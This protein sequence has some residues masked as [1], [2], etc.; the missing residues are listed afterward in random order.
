MEPQTHYIERRGKSFGYQSV[1]SG[2]RTV[3]MYSEING[4]PDLLWTDP[5]WA[6]ACARLAGSAK[7]LIFQLMGLGLSDAIDRVPTLEEQ[8]SDL[9]A[10]LD[11]EGVESATIL[12]VTSTSMPVLLFAAR[13]PERVDGLMLLTPFARGPLAPGYDDG[14]DLTAA[15]AAAL[16]SEYLEIFARWGEGRLLEVWDP[17]IAARNRRIEGILERAAATPAVAKA[18]LGAAMLGDVRELLPLI[19]AP[20]RVLR[21]KTHFIPE[22]VA[23]VVADGIPGATFHELP[24]NLPHMTLGEVFLPAFE[25]IQAVVEDRQPRVG[26]ERQLASILF[27]DIVGSTGL[28]EQLGDAKWNELLARH[29]VQ[30]AEHVEAAGGRLLKLIGDGSVSVFPGPAAAIRAGRAIAAAAPELD[31]RVRSGVHTGECQRRPGG[32]ISGLAVHIAARVGA[33]AAPG[34]VWV[35]RTVRDLV[36]GSGLELAPRGSHELKGL[37]ERWELFSLSGEDR[38]GATVEAQPS[39]M[40]PGDRL[41]VAA[42]RRA[43][44][45]MRGLARLEY[46]RRRFGRQ[47]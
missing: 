40:R 36:G 26:E 11:A 17:V 41:A 21:H 30:I 10:V 24:P 9:G 29:E 43:P 15:E 1:G 31:L 38:A 25:H 35:S 37:T 6:E 39:A 20:T 47:R 19:Q 46:A 14:P 42:A 28:V 5:I 7:V 12:G 18:V 8:A 13:E 16:A 27:T 4:H 22:S 33:A 3:A 34:E 23:R 45:L 2:P 32:D 44:G